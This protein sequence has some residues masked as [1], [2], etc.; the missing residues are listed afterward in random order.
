M[1]VCCVRGCE[2]EKTH[3]HHV[4]GSKGAFNKPLKYIVRI[5]EECKELLN[6]EVNLNYFQCGGLAFVNEI[7]QDPK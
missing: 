1:L 4:H 7:W 3:E 6:Q 5:C 2:N